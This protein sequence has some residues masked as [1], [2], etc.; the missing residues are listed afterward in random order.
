VE[1]FWRNRVGLRMSLEKADEEVSEEFVSLFGQNP[2]DLLVP[3][4]RVETAARSGLVDLE[5]LLDQQLSPLRRDLSN[6]TAC[7]GGRHDLVVVG[8]GLG[9][10]VRGERDV[11]RVQSWCGSRPLRIGWLRG[12]QIG[13]GPPV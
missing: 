5:K 13:R 6:Q 2:L 9:L 7:E 3:A 11:R 8:T 10:G 1:L 4:G 12:R